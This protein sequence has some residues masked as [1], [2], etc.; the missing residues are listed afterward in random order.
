MVDRTGRERGRRV[1]EQRGA[2]NHTGV[3]AVTILII[4][5][6]PAVLAVAPTVTMPTM[7]AVVPIGVGARG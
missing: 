1:N 2:N 4:V 5:I 6:A 3:P 7:P